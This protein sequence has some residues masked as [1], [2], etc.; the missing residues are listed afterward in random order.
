MGKIKDLFKNLQRKAYY[1]VQFT[2]MAARLGVVGKTAHLKA[3]EDS[4]YVYVAV[5]KR[6]EK[7]GQINFVLKGAGEQEVL[8]HPVLDLLYKPNPHQTKNEFFELYQTY[9]DLVGATFIY[10]I[11]T[12]EKEIPS[13]MY[14]LRPD[15]VTV[16]LAEDGTVVGYKYKVGLEAK[17][18][19]MAA[20]DVIA[21]FYPS[22]LKGFEGHSPLMAG[23]KTVDT[24]AALS[25]YHRSV[26]QNGGKVEGILKFKT[27]YLA[28]EQIKE[29]REQW[30][31]EM[32]GAEHSGLPLVLYG[33]TDYQNLGLS[34]TELSFIESRKMTRDDILALYGIP[35]ALFAQDVGALGGNGYEAAKRMFLSETIKPLLDNLV[36]KLNE[37]LVPEPMNLE[38]I[39]PT[40]EDVELKLKEAESG[41]KNSYLKINEVRELMGYE[42][43]PE[44]DVILQPF[45]LMPLGE[46]FDDPEEPVEKA[47]GRTQHAL[48]NKNVRDYYRKQSVEKFERRVRIFDRALN[49]YLREQSDRLITALGGKKALTKNVVDEAFNMSLEVDL[50]K[51]A[52]LPFFERFYKE[53]GED[54]ALFAGSGKPFKLGPTASATLAKRSKF[55]AESMNKTT[56]KELQRQFRISLDKG[57]PREKLIARIEK[58]Y[59]G[60]S[61]ARAKTIARTE[62]H[63]AVQEGTFAGYKDAGMTTKIWVAVMDADTRD[64]HVEADGEEV[65]IDQVFSNG[66]MFPG[67]PGGSAEETVNCRCTL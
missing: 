40:P 52:L 8:K 57:E 24:E 37:F 22:P 58:T 16:Q 49:K 5:K 33:D 7:V 19:T 11:R 62:V 47:K 53:A 60:I 3:Y 29:I 63:V 48:R 12:G 56:F 25:E 43:V 66:L 4:L 42:P 67:D 64:S 30:S 26:L 28:R 23:G 44:G 14:L 34:P 61:K 38:F 36:Q 13:E 65:P 6:A 1:G 17:E 15:R 59:K 27:E 51:T 55:F 32:S 50:A 45:G 31:E 46:T 35:L 9:K 21:S 18:V 41:L 10:L 2:R 54:A 20:S 39:D